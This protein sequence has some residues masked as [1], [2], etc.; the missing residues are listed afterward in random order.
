MQFTPRERHG[1]AFRRGSGLILLGPLIVIALGRW[2]SYLKVPG[3]PFYLPDI[4]I[5]LGVVLFLFAPGIRNA[6]QSGTKPPNL[7]FKLALLSSALAGACVLLGMTFGTGLKILA[8]RDAMPFVYIALI[9]VM[10]R[11]IEDVG[12]DTALRWLRNAV[13]VHTLWITPVMF[14]L[15]SPFQVPIIGGVP[16]FTP[17]HDFDMLVCG[18]AV[19]LIATDRRV[20]KPIAVLLVVANLASMFL[21]GSRAGLIAGLAIIVIFVVYTRPFQNRT[22]GP[23]RLSI[24]LVLLAIAIPLVVIYRNN[25]PVW[26]LGLQKLL[27]N[28]GDEYQSG[29][30]TWN[31]RVSAWRLVT[32]YVASAGEYTQLRG[33]GFG[34]NPIMDSGAVAYLSGD[35]QVRAAHNFLVTW[36]A[37]LGQAGIVLILMMFFFLLVAFIA[38]IRS[39]EQF[40]LVGIS[41]A[42]GLTL[43]GLG[44]VILESP[45]GY[46]AFTFGVALALSNKSDVGF[47]YSYTDSYKMRTAVVH[48]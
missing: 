13:I 25:P 4:V 32:D 9:P 2:G 30:N 35:S 20:V 43:S 16:A 19:V 31:A 38:A 46:M 18:L 5:G 23:V 22:K 24:T 41:L 40:A 26:A 14:D 42:V 47:N 11:A 39:R 33:L 7:S 44:G 15:L 6:V 36:Y 12:V 29:Q 8:I 37:F 28:G 45:F 34:T 1:L 17:R 10:I 48:A 27:P 21:S 3:G